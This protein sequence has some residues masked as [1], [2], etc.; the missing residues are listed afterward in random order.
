MD[1]LVPIA[2]ALAALAAIGS[3]FVA[4]R[5]WKSQEKVTMKSNDIHEKANEIFTD[6]RDA[7]K[8]TQIEANNLRI[9]TN[10]LQ[11][12]ANE[13][14]KT[15]ANTDVALTQRAQLVLL[16]QYWAQIDHIDSARPAQVVR[17]VNNL[18]LVALCWEADIVDRDIINRTFR[19]TFMTLYRQL[20][21]CP[22]IEV[23]KGVRRTGQDLLDENPSIKNLFNTFEKEE[24][25]GGAVRRLTS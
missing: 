16:W 4:W 12:E 15:I 25:A 20:E 11:K 24:V 13:L 23:G 17:T 14:Q 8:Q 6:L 22:E 10:E 3:L 7:T 1:L 21:R 5:V 9:R 18:E 19:R 2:T